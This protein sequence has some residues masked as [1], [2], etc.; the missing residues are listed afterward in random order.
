M[1]DL[2][3]LLASVHPSGG[4][5]SKEF[6]LFSNKHWTPDN[7]GCCL[8]WTVP[9][10]T[11]YIKFEILSGGGPGCP[12][13]P[14]DWGPGGM[15]GNYGMKQIFASGECVQGGSNYETRTGATDSGTTCATACGTNGSC[16][17]CVGQTGTCVLSPNIDTGTA[18]YTLCVAGT[19]P[20]SCCLQCQIHPCHRHGCP[21]YVNG[22]GLGTTTGTYQDDNVNF[23]VLGGTQGTHFC[24]TSCSCYN[25]FSPGQCCQARWNAGWNRSMCV[26]GFGYDQF[27]AGTSG[28]IYADYSCNSHETSSPGHPTG[29]FS[30][31]SGLSG[32]KCSCSITCC[33]GHSHWPGGG[34]YAM[35]DDDTA[36]YGGYGA[37]GLIKVTYQ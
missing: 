31:P 9:E 8:E 22:P 32:D 30:A 3:T 28:Y 17:P 29:P 15:G 12:G 26:C 19:S 33:S 2:S 11:S 6:W 7:G 13:G 23:C 21:S 36:Y 24:D 1:V 27:F 25:C 35:L 34:G 16:R 18:V 14:G 20:C 4:S 37:G 10:K 5:A